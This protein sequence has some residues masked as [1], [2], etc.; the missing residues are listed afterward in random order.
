[1]GKWNPVFKKTKSPP[2][3]KERDQGGASGK[4]TVLGLLAEPGLGCR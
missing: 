4:F 3:R 1:M 2:Y